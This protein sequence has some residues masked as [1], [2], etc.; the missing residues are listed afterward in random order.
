MYNTSAEDA[1]QVAAAVRGADANAVTI[2]DGV[3]ES[4][5]VEALVGTVVGEL[6]AFDAVVN[7]TGIVDPDR[8]TDLADE[9]WGRTLETNLAGS[10]YVTRVA[11]PHLQPGGDGVFVSATSSTD[12][13]VDASYAASKA[14]LYSLT[15]EFG[16]DGVQISAV[17][18]G[19]V[20]TEING[21]DLAYPRAVDFR[22]HGS[23][24]THLPEYACEPET[25]AH[26]G[27]SLPENGYVRGKSSTATCSSSDAIASVGAAFLAYRPLRRGMRTRTNRLASRVERAVRMA[28]GIRVLTA[29]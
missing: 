18:S 6:G 27:E 21:E 11:M 20:G 9:Q 23:A 19:P 12:G 7:D 17:A 29:N 16:P 22:G 28:S 2:Q 10:F 13:T 3:T 5:A 15:R 25:V 1:A 4:D 26:A 24:D 8:L 14:G